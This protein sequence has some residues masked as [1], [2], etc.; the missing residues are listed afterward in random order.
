MENIQLTEAELEFI[1]LK[2]ES[3]E[4]AA[5]QKEVEKQIKRQKYIEIE[6]TKIERFIS[7]DKTKGEA[8][9]AFLAELNN[10]YKTP[11]YELITNIRSK[12]FQLY[13]YVLD[14]PNDVYFEE[15]IK[16]HDYKI[17]RIGYTFQLEIESAER[18]INGRYGTEKYW[19]LHY[20]YKNYKSA[21]TVDTKINEKIE[22]I[23]SKKILEQKQLS[24]K[25][26]V[27]SELKSKYPEATIEHGSEWIL[28]RWDKNDRGYSQGYFTV[29]FEN[30]VKLKC[31]YETDGTYSSEVKYLYNVMS[32]EEL[33]ELV[34]NL[35]K[36]E[37]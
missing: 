29:K 25:E 17:K 9:I 4:L 28:N 20:D 8:A 16:Y 2:R 1:K 35:P 23:E 27:A 34:K 5:K 15:N 7:E 26:I 19:A 11:A 31:I 13:D 21:K 22:R 30:G 12:Q 36:K 3:E 24:S 6:K 14:G 10:F 32:Q 18:K 33:I 37:K